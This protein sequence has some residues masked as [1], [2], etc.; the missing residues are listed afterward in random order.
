MNHPDTKINVLWCN[1]NIHIKN[2]I[3]PSCISLDRIDC[4]SDK[5]PNIFIQVEP[6]IILN[7]TIY[8]L[9]N[10]KKYHTI[11]TYDHDVLMSCSNTRFYIVADCWISPQYYHFIDVLKKEFKISTLAGSKYMNSA[12]GHLFRQTI[13][14]AQ[15]T[16]KEHPIIFFRSSMQIPHIMDYGNNPLL[17]MKEELFDTFQFAIVIENSKQRNYFTEKIIDCLITKTIPIYYG[18]PNIHQFFDTTGW[19]I[20]ESDDIT[21]LQSKLALLDSLYY[22]KYN[23]II[24]KNFIKAQEYSNFNNNINNSISREE[25]ISRYGQM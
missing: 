17:S 16:L 10:Y 11:V 9:N 18:C 20:L 2:H 4:I 23:D 19:I 15:N 22:A 21:I 3:Q 25:Y 13:H 24:E 7:Y 12:K 14:H 5:F 8:L 6:A 1:P